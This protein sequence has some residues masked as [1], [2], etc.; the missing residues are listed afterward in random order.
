MSARLSRCAL[1]Y[2]DLRGVRGSA[3]E[4]AEYFQQ[5]RGAPCCRPALF[6]IGVHPELPF[7]TLIVRCEHQSTVWAGFRPGWE[8]F[9]TR[10]A[11]LGGEGR[12]SLVVRLWSHPVASRA[13]ST[14]SQ[15]FTKHLALSVGPYAVV[16][17]LTVTYG[18]MRRKPR[19]S[20]RGG[21]QRE[22]VSIQGS[23]KFW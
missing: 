12:G 2:H 1:R 6:L 18:D 23:L 8:G 7:G 13:S 20:A 19:A 3:L 5:L 15:Y 17:S 22:I 14:L 11:G 4:P 9:G 16:F 21:S 10:R